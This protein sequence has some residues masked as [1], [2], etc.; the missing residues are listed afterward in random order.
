MSYIDIYVLQKNLFCNIVII[1]I[2]FFKSIEIHKK[3]KN[4]EN[5][6]YIFNALNY[7]CL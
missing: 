3:G 2:I 6:I 4:E 5:Q 1:S 7:N